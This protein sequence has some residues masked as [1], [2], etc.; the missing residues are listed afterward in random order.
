MRRKPVIK[1]RQCGAVASLIEDEVDGFLCNNELDCAE[2]IRNL[3]T[4]PSQARAMG[5]NDY[6]KT[7]ERFT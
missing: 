4:S 7:I 6:R 3:L 1:N 2:R 5:E